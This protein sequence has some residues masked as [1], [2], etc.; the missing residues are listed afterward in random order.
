MNKIHEKAVEKISAAKDKVVDKLPDTISDKLKKDKGSIR[1]TNGTV[2][3]HRE[4][5]LA[6][7]HKFKYPFQY[8]KHKILINVIAIVVASIVIFSIWLWFMLYRVQA[9]DDFFYYSV[10]ILPLPVANVDGENVPFSNY[11]R[12]LRSQI[13]YKEN[14][15]ENRDFSTEDGQRELNYIRRQ[16]L[17]HN[18][19]IAYATKIANSKNISVSDEEVEKEVERSLVDDSGAKLTLAE[20]EKNVLRRY[21]NWSIDEYRAVLRNELLLSKVM[22]EVKSFTDDFNKLREQNKIH[23]YIE[24][25]NVE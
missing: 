7:G 11:M 3:E 20:Y 12:R 18:A 1:I 6:T 15:G 9:T 19:K 25:P 13:F 22:A 24:V 4:K 5:V 17:N 14:G 21:Y 8:S 2:T 23:E 10:K 16:E